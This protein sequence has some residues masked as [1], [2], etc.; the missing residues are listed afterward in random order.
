MAFWVKP[1]RRYDSIMSLVAASNTIYALADVYYSNMK[2][3]DGI[4]CY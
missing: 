1:E 2:S 4:R 3:A